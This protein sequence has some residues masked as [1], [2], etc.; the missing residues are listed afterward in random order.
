MSSS[1]TLTKGSLCHHRSHR[2][3]INHK[4]RLKKA[5]MQTQTQTP[6]V[7][8]CA[9]APPKAQNVTRQRQQ[10][11]L[12]PDD[13]HLQPPIS[14]VPRARFGCGAWHSA[15]AIKSFNCC[16]LAL[17]PANSFFPACTPAKN[18][19]EEC[20]LQKNAEENLGQTMT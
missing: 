19:C 14:T 13:E 17:R 8:S 5:H 15:L 7:S 9:P 20:F 1:D 11:K 3:D 10:P 12:P 2:S 6:Y 16:R 4:I 18:V